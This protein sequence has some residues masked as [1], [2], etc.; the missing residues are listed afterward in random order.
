[1][2]ALVPVLRFMWR[3]GR[4]LA[5]SLIAWTVLTFTYRGLSVVFSALGERYSALQIFILGALVCMILATLS[6]I[7]TCLWRAR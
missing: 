6:W 4:L 2:L 1:M 3:P 5:S 7:G